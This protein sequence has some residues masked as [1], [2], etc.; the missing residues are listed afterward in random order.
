MK[1]RSASTEASVEALAAQLLK[2]WGR[3]MRGSTKGLYALLAELDL[4]M[5]QMKTLHILTECEHEISVKEL[6]EELAMSLPNASRTVEHLLQR[7][8]VERREDEHDRRMKRIAATDAGREVV[9]RIETARLQGLEAWA[10]DLSPEQRRTLL[11]ALLT[12]PQ[13]SRS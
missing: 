6:A 2:L 9:Q 7:G 13:D 11:D 3:L 8:L 4:S 10:G 5:T 12:L 1:V